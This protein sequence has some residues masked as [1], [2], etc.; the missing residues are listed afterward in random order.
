[1]YRADHS[2]VRI[3]DDIS[4]AV[5]WRKVAYTAIGFG[6]VSA[7]RVITYNLS[8]AHQRS[9]RRKQAVDRRF[10]IIVSLE[11]IE[12]RLTLPLAVYSDN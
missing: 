6:S 10:G 9:K 4:Y 8:H 1:M 2:M 3:L 7:G 11:Y 12:K 5:L